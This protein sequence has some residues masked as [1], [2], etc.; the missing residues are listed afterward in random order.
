VPL[1]DDGA[2]LSPEDIRR[3]LHELRVHQI[4]LGQQNDELRRTQAELDP[5]RARYLDLYDLAPVGYVTLSE[6]GL[7]LEANLTVA[8]LLG[9]TRTELVKQP[10]SRFVFKDD[11]DIDY[12][13]RKQLFASREPQTYDVRMEKGDGTVFWAHIDETASQDAAGEPVC[14][15]TL[16]DITERRQAEECCRPFHHV[17]M[18]TLPAKAVH[19]GLRDT[20][21][22]G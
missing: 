10:L 12:L 21:G 18:S 11:Q 19:S 4:E 15:T 7:I 2:S 14:R 9:V 3:T 20:E 16:S 6:R 22:G 17:G 5:S 8:S 13:H 1:T